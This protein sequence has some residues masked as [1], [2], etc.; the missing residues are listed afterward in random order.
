MIP[1]HYW[2]QLLQC[3]I[4]CQ[5]SLCW[6]NWALSRVSVCGHWTPLSAP[7]MWLSSSSSQSSSLQPSSWPRFEPG[8]ASANRSAAGAGSAS[9]LVQS[10]PEDFCTCFKYLK[11]TGAEPDNECFYGSNVSDKVHR[12][13]WN[14]FRLKLRRVR[15]EKSTAGDFLIYFIGQSCLL[16]PI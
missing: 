13:I 2:L 5:S 3:P 4:M 6:W 11:K 15:G 16:K 1:L 9:A 8:T 14:R 12:W 10:E 7:N